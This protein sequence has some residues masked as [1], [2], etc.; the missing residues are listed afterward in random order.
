MGYF[1][2][3]IVI[4]YFIPLPNL[5]RIK[6]IATDNHRLN[7]LYPSNFGTTTHSVQKLSGMPYES[8]SCRK[9]DIPPSF[10]LRHFEEKAQ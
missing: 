9:I 8:K 7:F 10:T 3:K 4:G 2:P 1:C 5:S 6:Q